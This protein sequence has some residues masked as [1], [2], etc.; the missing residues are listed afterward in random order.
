MPYRLWMV[1]FAAADHPSLVIRYR[2]ANGAIR[3]QI[4]WFGWV[5]GIIAG[6]FVVMIA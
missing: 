1:W 3:Q 2:S 4:K 6:T 5:Y